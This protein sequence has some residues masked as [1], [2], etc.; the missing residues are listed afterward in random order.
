[1]SGAKLAASSGIVA[2]GIAL[3]LAAPV[4]AAPEPLAPVISGS[5]V[6]GKKLTAMPSGDY[7]YAWQR[8][9]G[10][11]PASC[12]AGFIDGAT[13]RTYKLREE[14]P[15]LLDTRA[16]DPD[17]GDGPGAQPHPARSE[18]GPGR[19]RWAR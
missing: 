1:M 10:K 17:P 11:E 3:A 14:G 9:A 5:T 8:C 12:P 18:P 4:G 15:A 19:S 16:G 6:V 7:S 2:G 13:R